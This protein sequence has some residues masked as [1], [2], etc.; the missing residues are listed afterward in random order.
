MRAFKVT[1]DDWCPSYKLSGYHRG[2]KNPL[3]VEVSHHELTNG[4][5]RVAVW[6]GDDM[7]ME[8]DTK[9]GNKARKLLLTILSWEVVSK[10][11]LKELGFVPA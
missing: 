4:E 6:G 11:K 9:S 2:H 5:Y 10:E 7:G 3:L 8:F 1:A